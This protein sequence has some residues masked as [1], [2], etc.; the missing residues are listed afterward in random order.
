MLVDR[1]CEHA[2]PRLAPSPL[3]GEFVV[4]SVLAAV[5][6]Q[7]QDPD[8]P[9]LVALLN[10]LMWMIALPYLGPGAAAKRAHAGGPKAL[11]AASARCE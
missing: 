9:Q 8:A 7:M 10:T 6:A 4:G 1:G 11:R 2:S 3:T 5:H